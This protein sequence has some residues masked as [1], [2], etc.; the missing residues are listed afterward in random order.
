MKGRL[1]DVDAA[2]FDTLHCCGIKIPTHP[3][4]QQKCG[5]LLD[6]AKSGLRAKALLAPNGQ[7]AAKS[8]TLRGSSHGAV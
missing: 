7:P 5:W 4:R 3:G 2:S 8:N 1:I 6:N